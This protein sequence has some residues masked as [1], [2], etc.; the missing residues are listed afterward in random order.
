MTRSCAE[1]R[2][3]ASGASTGPAVGPSRFAPPDVVNELKS[4]I[5]VE[6]HYL[7][8]KDQYANRSEP[9]HRTTRL[10]GRFMLPIDGFPGARRSDP[11]TQNGRPERIA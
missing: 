8:P 2:A 1:S 11:S 9:A 10:R 5:R 6:F 4:T 3:P 7:G